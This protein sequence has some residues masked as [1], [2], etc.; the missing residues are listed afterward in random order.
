F[1]C[2]VC[3]GALSQELQE[4]GVRS[5]ESGVRSTRRRVRLKIR[6]ENHFQQT[7]VFKEGSLKASF[8]FR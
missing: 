1:A 3:F 7:G 8:C 2:F 6:E 5:Q 4:S